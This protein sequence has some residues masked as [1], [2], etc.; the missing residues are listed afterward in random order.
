M[1]SHEGF[2]AEQLRSFSVPHV[3]RIL[4]EHQHLIGSGSVLCAVNRRLHVQVRETPDEFNLEFQGDR[5]STRL[6]SSHYS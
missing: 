4:G 5:K 6:N 3:L 1:Q 2:N